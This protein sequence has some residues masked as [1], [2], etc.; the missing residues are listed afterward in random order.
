MLVTNDSPSKVARLARRK[1]IVNA[2]LGTVG[3]ASAS[4]LLY[5]EVVGLVVGNLG[6]IG[7]GTVAN[8]ALVFG[9][10]MFLREARRAR[11]ELASQNDDTAQ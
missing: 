11:A 1:V 5:P 9:S 6:V 2:G 4:L 7:L 8:L 3:L 10:L